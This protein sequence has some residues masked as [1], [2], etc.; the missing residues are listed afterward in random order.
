[1]GD[2]ILTKPTMSGHL[3]LA[4]DKGTRLSFRNGLFTLAEDGE[5]SHFQL[6]QIMKPVI[7]GNL[8]IYV[9]ASG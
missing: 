8:R 1:M 5:R 4:T 6:L 3:S 9:G 7:A 2:Y